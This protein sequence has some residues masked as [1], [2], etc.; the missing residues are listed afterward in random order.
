MI[1]YICLQNT[2]CYMIKYWVLNPQSNHV[3]HVHA[4]GYHESPFMKRQHSVQGYT[5]GA[6]FTHANQ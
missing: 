2:H 4:T 3:K 6:I 1:Q 5:D